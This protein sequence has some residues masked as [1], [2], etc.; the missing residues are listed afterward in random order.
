M[1]RACLAAALGLLALL[2]GDVRACA[3]CR[4][5]NMPVTRVES[6]PLR[7][8]EFRA[9]ASLGA[10][11]VH[12][13]HEAGCPDLAACDER[14]I[15][16]LYLHDQ[17]LFPGELRGI[18]ELGMTASLGVEVQIP[19]RLVHT[20]IE[21][22]TPDGQPYEPLDPGV[23]HRDETLFGL[24]DPWLLGRW[25]G[26]LGGLL[27]SARAGVSIPLGGTEPN[28]F[29]LGESGQRHQHIQFGSGAFEPIFAVDVSKAFGRWLCV[30]YAQGQM[31][32]YENGHGFR[33]GMKANGGVQ[34]GR[35]IWRAMTGALGMEALHEGAER[36]DGKT[37]QD[38]SL[39]RTEVLLTLSGVQ[40]FRNGSLGLSAR[41]PVYRHIVTGDEPPGTLSSPLMVGLFA[42]RTFRVGSP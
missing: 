14:P 9:G 10:T 28:P 4:N 13:T 3:G 19:L 32:L 37:L 30:G 31:S 26:Q 18:G 6:V 1:R 29:V 23:H 41:V 40:A 21:Y 17:R 5:P 35:R 33:S 12:V 15:Q 25:A 24:G 42:S 22:A 8:G 39:G 7:S 16:P 36:W 38:G 2:P 27:V 11:G 34:A 20:S